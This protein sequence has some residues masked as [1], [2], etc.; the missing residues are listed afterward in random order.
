MMTLDPTSVQITQRYQAHHFTH[1]EAIEA[2]IR[3]IEDHSKSFAFAARLLPTQMRE[4]V[5][6]LYAWC[7]RVDDAIDE[8]DPSDVQDALSILTHQLNEV[9]A[10]ELTEAVQ[11][12]FIL[13]SLR[14]VVKRCHIPKHYPNEL[15]E[16]M[17]M[18]V[19]GTQYQDLDTLYLY[20]YRVASVVGLMMC[21]IMQI[22]SDIALHHAAHL[23]LAM[24]LTNICRDVREDWELG[25]LYLPAELLKKTAVSRC[26]PSTQE[27]S[28]MLT[29]HQNLRGENSKGGLYDHQAIPD[30][31]CQA[32]QETTLTLLRLADQS[33]QRGYQGIAY[34][35]WRPSIAIHAAG[36]IYQDIGRIIRDQGCDPLSPRAFTTKA[37]KVWLAM[38]VIGMRSMRGMGYVLSLRWL[39]VHQS[40]NKPQRTLTFVEL[41]E[42]EINPHAD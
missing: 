33:Y 35:P 19:A 2:C 32:S 12:D 25:R 28:K 4:D 6:V 1:E 42:S 3:I 22:K 29:I 40:L 14:S 20:C 38:K 7:R 30:V 34:L 10:D 9:Y 11:R 8:S 41:M 17:K 18:D 26:V 27:L 23:G 37:R 36:V 13:R 15:L 5:A 24:Q 39:H 21:H 31:L 16:G